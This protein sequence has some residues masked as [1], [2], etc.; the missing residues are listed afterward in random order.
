MKI[1]TEL[2][3]IIAV[4]ISLLILGDTH[5][6]S[7]PPPLQEVEATGAGAS[8]D[9]AFRQAVVD[10]VRQV[11]GALV[12]AE[13]VVN[14]DRVIKDEV[15]TM[16]NG[17]VE[18]VLNQDKAKLDDG[19]WQVKLKC[20]VRKG[21]LYGKLQK[22]NVPTI[23]FDGVSM[24]ADVVSQSSFRGD[25]NKMLAKAVR[26]FFRGYPSIYKYECEKPK[27][28]HAGDQTTK[29][30]IL[31]RCTVDEERY[32]G[33]LL[34]P[35]REALKHAAKEVVTIPDSHLKGAY[36][37]AYDNHRRTMGEVIV[38]ERSGRS[39]YAIEN[40]ILAGCDPRS[41]FSYGG[42]GWGGS[43]V[44]HSAALLLFQS[45]DNST[46]YIVETH[47][48]IDS[49]F[50]TVLARLSNDSTPDTREIEAE[51]PT[52][53][54]PNIAKISMRLGLDVRDYI[55]DPNNSRYNGYSDGYSGFFDEYPNKPFC[56]KGWLVYG[57]YG[58]SLTLTKGLSE[59]IPYRSVLD[60]NGRLYYLGD[61]LE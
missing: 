50:H 28:V 1:Q 10:A 55:I 33:T 36:T 37:A 57:V 30:K 19:T 12:S 27:L 6:E 7:G 16:S 23:K 11:V 51:L 18:K 26:E 47:S 42:G 46:Q 59:K 38:Q 32:Y 45:S 39:V 35:L 52:R 54:L 8:Q 48:N 31:F 34:P 53:L 4:V 56:S 61:S 3:I 21:Q 60:P 41:A 22:A 20:I 24:F 49:Q 9:E 29:V 58:G 5:A 17:F 44:N 15:L 25:A 2:Y 14:N 40:E 13:N 43:L